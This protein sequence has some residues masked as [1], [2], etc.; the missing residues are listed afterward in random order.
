MNLRRAY[1]EAAIWEIQR[2]RRLALHAWADAM[3][4][5]VIVRSML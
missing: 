4:R 1:L 3:V 2:Q 5:L